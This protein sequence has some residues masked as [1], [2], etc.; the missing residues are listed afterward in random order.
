MSLQIWIYI[1]PLVVVMQTAGDVYV[2]VKAEDT[3]NHPIYVGYFL[4]HLRL[5]TFGRS[6]LSKPGAYGALDFY[7]TSF[8]SFE[9]I[10][11]SVTSILASLYSR[12]RFLY[13]AFGCTK[14]T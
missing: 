12:R 2:I 9:R 3:S 8:W 14:C 6:Y 7:S 1:V 4:S 10:Q 5:S 11:V 13:T